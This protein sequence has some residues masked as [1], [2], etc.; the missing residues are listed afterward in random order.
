MIYCVVPEALKDEL[1]DK[2]VEH[3]K[4]DPNV[5]VI[6][7]R[8]SG[9]DRRKAAGNTGP[10]ERREVRDRRKRRPPGSFPP[11]HGE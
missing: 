11:L 8:R 5:E 3:Y 7:D 9:P 10:D 2:L 6:I 1:Y 4:D